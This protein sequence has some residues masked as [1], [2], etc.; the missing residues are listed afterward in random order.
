MIGSCHSIIE[1]RIGWQMVT[2][3]SWPRINAQEQ[4]M[5]AVVDGITTQEDLLP[6]LN[7]L[8]EFVEGLSKMF[9]ETMWGLCRPRR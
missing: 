4:F 2:I 5:Y 8:N 6:C 3:F 1:R 7:V 9:H